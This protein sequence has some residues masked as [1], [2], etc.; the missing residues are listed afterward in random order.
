MKIVMVVILQMNLQ[1]SYYLLFHILL[2]KE[3]MKNMMKIIPIMVK[4]ALK[5]FSDTVDEL[6][7]LL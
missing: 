1:K 6:E 7:K 3:F 5:V 2:L 4:N